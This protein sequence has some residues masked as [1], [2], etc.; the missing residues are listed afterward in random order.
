MQEQKRR[1]K[2]NTVSSLLFQI[3]NIVCGFILPRLI[4]ASFGSEVNGL[5]GSITQ[6]LDLIV[7]LEMGVGA[8]VQA[9]LY[10]PLAERDERAVSEIAS[11]AGRFFSRIALAL[12]V[13]A[14]VLLFVYPFFVEGSFDFTYTAVLILAIAV[15]AFAQYYFGLV[16]RLLLTA[17]QRGYVQYAAQTITLLANTAACA[18]LIKCGASIQ[19]VKLGTALIFLIRPI[20]LRLYVDRHYSIDR[21]VRC[22]GEPIQQKWNGIAQHVSYYVLE[23]TDVIV[24]T[25]LSTLKNVSVYSVYHMVIYGVKNLFLSLTYGVQALMG[26][27]IARKETERLQSLF[28]WT[29]WLLH[30]GTV[31][32]FGCTGVLILPFIQVYTSGINDA[33]YQV[34]LFAALITLAHAGHCLRLPYDLLILAAGHFRQTQRCH[35]TAALLNVGISVLTVKLW[36]LVGVAIGTLCAMA[37]QT[38]WMAVYDSRHILKNS[39][40]SFAKHLL[41]D[42]LTALPAS[43]ISIQIPM[44]SV[45]YGAWILLAFEVAGVWALAVF[46]INALF[47]RDKVL[48]LLKTLRKKLKTE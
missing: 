22:E 11:S 14:V 12:G 26:E 4:L 41:V 38:V 18:I 47:Y 7:F 48:R 40:R 23:K 21:K 46:G 2:L 24:L 10:K 19:L 25:L 27:L 13:Y 31:F 44:G 43:L 16:D 34:P 33:N 36:G 17:D 9:S 30:T 42:M 45:S 35:I 28:E 3:T 15:S 39:I 5:V 20:A 32:V 29:E 1:L 8:V 6:F 37:Y